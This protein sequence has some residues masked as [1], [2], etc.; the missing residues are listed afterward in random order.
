M[1][2]DGIRAKTVTPWRATTQSN[3]RWA[4][5]ENTLTC[6]FTVAHPTRVWAGDRT[7]M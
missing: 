2:I 1:R 6:Q 4:L 3:H 7:D 5:A